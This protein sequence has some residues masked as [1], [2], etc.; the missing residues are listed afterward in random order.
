MTTFPSVKSTTQKTSHLLYFWIFQ[1]K[2][3]KNK[4]GQRDHMDLSFIFRKSRSARVLRSRW[5]LVIASQTYS[6]LLEWF[7]HSKG[8]YSDLYRE[9]TEHFISLF[10]VLTG[11]TLLSVSIHY[12]QCI[13]CLLHQ[14]QRSN[15]RNTHGSKEY[16]KYIDEQLK[17]IKTDAR[18]II[19]TM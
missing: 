16:Q 2:N 19:S 5:H 14:R 17:R 12:L 7:R 15:S 18:N 6:V 1:I 4:E 13:H 8:H 11:I 3:R 10:Y 9:D